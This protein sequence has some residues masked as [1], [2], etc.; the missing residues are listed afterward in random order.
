MYRYLLTSLLAAAVALAQT[1]APAAPVPAAA[2]VPNY[3]N[4][5]FPP[6][7]DV[8][9]PKVETFTLPNG[10]KV[11]LLENHELPL[12]S[13]TALVRTGNLFDPKDKAGLA[14][15]TGAVMRSGG[16]KSRTP[17]QLNTALENIAASVE[18]G[19]GE[20][21]GTVSFSALK[22]NTAEVLAIFKDV[23]TQPAF[24]NDKF[25]L[26]KTQ[27]RSGISRRND[28]AMGIAQREFASLL[29]D[30]NTPYGWQEEYATVDA[31]KREDLIAF[32]QRYFFPANIRL[33]I[34]GDFN[35]AEM[36]ASLEK[37]F[38]DWNAQQPPVPAFPQVTAKPKPGIYLAEKEDVTQT[39]LRIGHLGGTLKDKD[40]PALDVMASILGGG[41]PSRLVRK[42]RSEKGYA[43][44]IG[45][46]WGA[47]YNHPGAFFMGGS[48]KAEAT[49]ET[50]GALQ[51]EISKLRNVEVTDQELSTAKNTA[52]NSFVFNFAS[53]AQ[54]LNRMVTYD[55]HGYPMD[56]L[57]TYKKAVESVTKADILR[58]A[59]EFVKPENFTVV[60]V[61]NPKKF[62][63]KDLKSLGMPVEK[64]DLTIPQPKGAEKA[65]SSD[66]TLA[67][68]KA[69][70]SKV[71][72]ALGGADKI[73][74]IKDYEQKVTIALAQGLTVNQTNW[75]LAPGAI[76]QE[77][78]LPFG[79]I[80]S[81][82][83]GAS[84][85]WAK[86][87][88][89]KMPLAGPVLNQVKQQLLQDFLSLLRSNQIE[90]R[91]VNY[92][93]AGKLDITEGST[94]VQLVVDEATGLPVKLFAD[95]VGP[96][97]PVKLEMVYADFKDVGGIKYP[98]KM[99]VMQG[100]QKFS[101]NTI[102]EIKVNTGVT[103][104]ALQKEQ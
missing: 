96:Q 4:L 32:H 85:G 12:V 79:K 5:K 11:F 24:A 89:G 57:Q 68:G 78:V 31:I 28:D 87:P 25:E 21:S 93:G 37:L 102:T 36:K 10:M 76:R 69:L 92:A 23:L 18:S 55:Y 30:K 53:P 104:E 15:M 73:L 65:A 29:Y 35:T 81:F 75:W 62:G 1:K 16:T 101:D 27:T 50:L 9:L 42:I 63:G 46:D 17:D 94:T 52:L 84:T 41:F 88:Q 13:G 14:S 20:T 56:F 45:A 43:Y 54:T 77:S 6:L 61:G 19:I 33:S 99:T 8:P 7:R 51:E 82:F 95:S 22:E 60:A 86:T 38:A 44:A 66:A 26:A 64:I 100:G 72:A 74:A 83:D 2:P 58:V 49:V 47:N 40:Y 91:T 90:G 70:L 59:K 103:L 3:K 67:Q 48:V 80:I 39:F 71:H 34:Y 98:H 97:G